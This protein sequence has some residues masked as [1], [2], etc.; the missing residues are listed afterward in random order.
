MTDVRFRNA[1][2]VKQDSHD[3]TQAG[4]YF[5]SRDLAV[6]STEQDV[7][8]VVTGT[9]VEGAADVLVNLRMIAATSGQVIAAT[10]F[11]MPKTGDINALAGDGEAFFK[12]GPYARD[13]NF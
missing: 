12:P 2:N 10:D 8:A 3:N 9:Y 11:R 4:E 6:I 5:L 13:Y 1:I 7:G